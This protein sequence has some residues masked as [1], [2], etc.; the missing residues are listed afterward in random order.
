MYNIIPV[1]FNTFSVTPNIRSIVYKYGM[2]NGGSPEDWDRMWD[3]YKIETVPQEQIKLLYGMANTH[4]M[5]LLVRY[6]SFTN[7]FQ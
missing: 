1:S 4:T 6:N 5:W 2:Q 3:K 7:V